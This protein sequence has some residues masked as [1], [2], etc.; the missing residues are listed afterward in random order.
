[1]PPT[2]DVELDGSDDLR[3]GRNSAGDARKKPNKSDYRA[4][5]ERVDRSTGSAWLN[6]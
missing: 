2:L 4:S 3:E 6:I 1:V 5:Y